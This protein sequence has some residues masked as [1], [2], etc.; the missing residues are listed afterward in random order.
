MPFSHISLYI[1]S[2]RCSRVFFAWTALYLSKSKIGLFLALKRPKLTPNDM[3]S[4]SAS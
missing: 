2:T 4:L 1:R 3:L